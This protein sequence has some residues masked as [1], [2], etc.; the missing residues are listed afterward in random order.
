[1]T[2]EEKNRKE[3]QDTMAFLGAISAGLED[4]EFLGKPAKGMAFL[5]GKELGKK[6]AEKYPQTDD[7]PKAIEYS[8]EM[9]EQVGFF[10][11]L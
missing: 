11:E 4:E 8:K 9:L 7:I 6:Y 3:L 5:A 2:E 1:M 10:S